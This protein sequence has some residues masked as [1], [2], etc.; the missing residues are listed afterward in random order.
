[1]SPE[2]VKVLLNCL[3]N[4]E[5]ELK[6]VKEIPFATKEWQIKNTQ[7]LKEMNSAITFINKRFENNNNNDKKSI[8]KENSYLTKRLE[9]SLR[10]TRKIF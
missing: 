5:I 7:Q 4:L 1:M 9:C 8:R 10:K 6:N 3:K 2:C